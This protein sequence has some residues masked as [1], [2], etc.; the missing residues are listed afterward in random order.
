[1]LAATLGEDAISLPGE[2]G[3]AI[4]LRAPQWIDEASER[5]DIA[6]NVDSLTE[7]SEA[8]ARKYVDFIRNNCKS[9]LSIN[10][11]INDFRAR[12]IVEDLFLMRHPDPMRDG[13]V[14]EFAVMM[15]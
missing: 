11:E 7:M 8:Y 4:K 12:D 3:A 9:F 1:M 5:F 10:H 15:T 13:Y 6:L 14:E 2:A